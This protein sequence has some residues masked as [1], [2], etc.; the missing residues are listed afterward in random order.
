[1]L[2]GTVVSQGAKVAHELYNV[3]DSIWV[4]AV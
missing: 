4:T 1:M 2:G 3:T